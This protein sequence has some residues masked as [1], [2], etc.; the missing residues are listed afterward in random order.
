MRNIRILAMPAAALLLASIGV[1]QVASAGSITGT[2]VTNPAGTTPTNPAGS[3]PMNATGGTPGAVGTTGSAV[4]TTG[5][6]V[7]PTECG[8]PFASSNSGAPGGIANPT[9]RSTSP[10]GLSTGSTV[11][12]IGC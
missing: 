6:A 11:G 3:T 12:S 1:A 7:G 5:R 8:F 9:T 4:G 2:T 10:N